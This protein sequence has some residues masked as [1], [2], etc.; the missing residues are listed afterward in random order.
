MLRPPLPRL[1]SATVVASENGVSVRV[2]SVSD[3]AAT[4]RSS[5]S[6][7]PASENS[8]RFVIVSRNSAR[9][10]GNFSSDGFQFGAVFGA[11]FGRF[12]GVG[13]EADHVFFF[14]RQRFEDFLRVGGQLGELVLLFGQLLKR[15]VDARRVGLARLIAASRSPPRPARPAPSSLKISR[16]RCA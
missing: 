15:F 3:G 11:R 13:E 16:K 9:K 4:P 5:S 12:A 1:F 10:V 14:A 8:L 2:A 6:G 7:V